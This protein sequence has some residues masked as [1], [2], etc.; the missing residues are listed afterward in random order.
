MRRAPLVFARA[1]AAFATGAT[2]LPA[3]CTILLGV[4]PLSGSDAGTDARE[5]TSSSGMGVHDAGPSA[6]TGCT[7]VWVDASGGYVPPGAVNAQSIDAQTVT[8]YVCRIA[9]G[10]DVVPGKLR[11]GY[12]CYFGEGDYD[13]GDGG[14]DFSIDYQ[15]LVPADCSATWMPA[16]DGV[17][18]ANAVATGQDSEGLLYSCRVTQ[19]SA[20]QGELGHVG[21]GTNHACV[22]SLSN[23]SLTSTVFDVLALY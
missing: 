10:N 3:G 7:A 17:T 9:W 13:A 8:I 12:G 14:E 18:P 1:L 22:Y 5:D 19:P 4:E 16:P 23:V 2:A 20:D 6:E 11:P 15:V 21:W